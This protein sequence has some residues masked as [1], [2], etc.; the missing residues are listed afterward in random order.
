[1]G[2]VASIK[3][4]GEEGGRM[5]L[6]NY[7]QLSGGASCSTLNIYFKGFHWWNGLVLF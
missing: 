5:W 2:H 7:T 3:S 6:I 1:M 4:V